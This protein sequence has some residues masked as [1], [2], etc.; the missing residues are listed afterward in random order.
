[1]CKVD[2]YDKMNVD[3]MEWGCNVMSYDENWLRIIVKWKIGEA[4]NSPTSDFG[5][6]VDLLCTY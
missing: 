5:F 2:V 1:M 3:I 6:Q 4:F